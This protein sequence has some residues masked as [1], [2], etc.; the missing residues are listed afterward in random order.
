[1]NVPFFFSSQ[2]SNCLRQGTLNAEHPSQLEASADTQR[3][4]DRILEIAHVLYYLDQVSFYSNIKTLS[5]I[6][7]DNQ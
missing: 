4:V 7:S 2:A 5:V 3:T 1:M 6:H